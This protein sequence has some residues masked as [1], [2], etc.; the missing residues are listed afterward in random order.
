MLF[1]LLLPAKLCWDWIPYFDFLS[2]CIDFPTAGDAAAA[3]EAQIQ[4][5]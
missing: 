3:V 1:I 2:L 5:I 4:R